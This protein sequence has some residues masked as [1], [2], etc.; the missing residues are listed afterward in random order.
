MA[1]TS[2]AMTMRGDGARSPRQLPQAQPDERLRLRRLAG[3]AQ[4]RGDGGG[5]LSLRIA[6]IDERRDRV[7]H[8]LRRA[9]VVDGVGEPDQRRIDG[10]ES[11]RLVLEL[12]DDAGRELRADAGRAGD[13]APCR[14]SRSR[15][16]ARRS[17]ASRGSPARPWRRRPARSAGGGTTPAPGRS[18][19]RR[20]GSCPRG[21]GSRSTASPPRRP[22]AGA[23]A[24]ATSNARGSRRHPR[25]R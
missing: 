7:R 11:R 17:R 6:E 14:R 8:G 13:G 25:R 3:L 22:R 9:P 18:G 23:A 24:C 5:G 4:R 20:A 19:S 2:P 10:A 1:G 15:S 21:H 12:G 16:R